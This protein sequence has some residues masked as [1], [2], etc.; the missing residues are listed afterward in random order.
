MGGSCALQCALSCFLMID[1]YQDT[2]R[3]RKVCNFTII[4][5]VPSNFA[6][7]LG[8]GFSPV[9]RLSGLIFIVAGGAAGSLDARL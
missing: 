6:V 9:I 2:F 3:A 8:R 7:H 5:T 1:Q 4:L